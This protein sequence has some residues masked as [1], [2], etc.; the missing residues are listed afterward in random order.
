MSLCGIGVPENL[1]SYWTWTPET[2]RW[3]NPKYSVKDTPREQF[4]WAESFVKEGKLD[5]VIDKH[6]Q[7]IEHYPTS[8]YAVTS[9]YRIGE[10]QLKKGEDLK[11]FWA[12]QKTIENYPKTSSIDKIVAKEFEIADS[13]F[14]GKRKRFA[15]IPIERSA[16]TA[17]LFEKVVENKP[18]GKYAAESQYKIGLSYLKEK[19]SEK[20]KEAFEKVIDNYPKSKWAEEAAYQIILF[21]AKKNQK[22][23]ADQSHLSETIDK[24]QEFKSTF[25]ESKKGKEIDAF[26]E[27]AREKEAEK[28]YKTGLFYEKKKERKS[29]IIYYEKIIRL[30]PKTKAAKTA[31]KKLKKLK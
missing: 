28:L 6:E 13:F 30:Y 25:S 16:K 20:A 29:A 1:L 14:K 15:K 2:S 31:E 23:A 9:Q 5:K 4:E 10:L 21:S 22:I 18:F 8:S 3:I 24:C 17:E 26:I 12:F 7:L 19:N 11:A 27:S